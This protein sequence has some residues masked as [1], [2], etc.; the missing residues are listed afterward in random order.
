M[1]TATA[2]RL[3]P[4]AG[5]E[6][7]GAGVRA[8]IAVCVQAAAELLAPSRR[9]GDDLI[10][11]G[12]TAPACIALLALPCTLWPRR[13]DAADKPATLRQVREMNA[14]LKAW[15]AMRLGKDAQISALME[16]SKRQEEEAAEKA[17]TVE[18]LRRKLA[19]ATGRRSSGGS[20]SNTGGGR[21]G[22]AGSNPAVS[23]GASASGVAATQQQ[24]QQQRYLHL[25]VHSPQHSTATSTAS[26]Q[27]QGR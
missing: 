15:E 27:L 2:A 11:A 3:V 7:Y 13:M 9:R 4:G 6:H 10:S 22:T 5:D 25:H 20:T 23:S 14:M 19:A 8:A 18:A 12:S 16:R 21:P 24:Q 1:R 26:F 17:R